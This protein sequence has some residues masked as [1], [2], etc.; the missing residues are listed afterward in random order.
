MFIMVMFTAICESVQ[1]RRYFE[2]ELTKVVHTWS[3]ACTKQHITQTHPEQG[4]EMMVRRAG[5]IR[6][7]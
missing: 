7:A 6:V 2:K 1:S 3:K 5:K 4:V